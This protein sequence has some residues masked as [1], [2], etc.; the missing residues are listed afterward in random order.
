MGTAGTLTGALGLLTST[1]A[2]DFADHKAQ[3]GDGTWL[4]ISHNYSF[5]REWNPFRMDQW[6]TPFIVQQI[7]EKIVAFFDK[8]ANF[9]E[10][11]GFNPLIGTGYGST[12]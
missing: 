12:M 4:G 11:V 7:G 5:N 2:R 10:N 3:P 6:N 8:S 1:L 9:S